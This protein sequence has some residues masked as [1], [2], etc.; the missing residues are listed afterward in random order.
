M[1]KNISRL[2]TLGL[3]AL[4]IGCGGQEAQVVERYFR[5]VQARDQQTMAGFSTVQFSGE[6]KSWK[7]TS[8][9][10]EQRSP[11]PLPDLDAKMKA[12]AEA[13]ANN[14][15]EYN[16]YFNAH[17]VEVDRVQKLLENKSAIPAGLAKT[18]ADW[19][20]FIEQDKALKA[21][22]ADAKAAYER[23][24]RLVSMSTGQTTDVEKLTGELVIKE[25]MI[26][27]EVD[28]DVKPH[29]MTLRKYDVSAGAGPKPM[30]RWL[31]TGLVAQ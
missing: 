12:A 17:P 10:E 25:V 11:A 28:G 15:K 29:K 4:A 23:E 13:E 27:L 7:V 16:A 31:I 1:T 26:D 14:K 9:G 2:A 6:V 22:A 5:A 20:K 24:K 30:S 3:A 19:Q 8:V 18:A 21:A